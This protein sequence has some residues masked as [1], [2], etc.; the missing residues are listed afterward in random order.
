[1]A[2]RNSS[3][4]E[5]GKGTWDFCLRAVGKK[6]RGNHLALKEEFRGYSRVAAGNV[7]ILSSDDGYIREPPGSFLGSQ[8][9]FPFARGTSGFLWCYCREEGL[10]LV[11]SPF[12]S[13][14]LSSSERVALKIVL[15]SQASSRV[16]TWY[17]TFFSSCKRSV[18]PQLS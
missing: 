10:H 13:E 8:N 11:L 14:F 9:A 16:Q 18:R 4:I 6:K 5:F 15:G 2:S 1:V 17:S 12:N 7:V 3:L